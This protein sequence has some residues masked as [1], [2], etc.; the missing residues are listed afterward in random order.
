MLDR[1]L[2]YFSTSE[3]GISP[4]ALILPALL[5]AALVY[6]W[7]CYRNW[8]SA[9]RGRGIRYWN[10][11]AFYG[12]LIVLALAL[13]GRMDSLVEDFFAAHMIQ[14]MLLILVAAPLLALGA[15]PQA[16][17]WALPRKTANAVAGG[18]GRR[19]K[20]AAAWSWLTSVWPAAVIFGVNLWFWHIPLFYQAALEL[21]AVH[22][23]EHVTFLLT[24]ALFWWSVTLAMRSSARGGAGL[25]AL[26]ATMLHM[27]LLGALINLASTPIY[28]FYH[29]GSLFG[30]PLTPLAD[31]Q[32]AGLVMWL[33]G[34]VIFFVL[35]LFYGM[36]W[37]ERVEENQNR[38][39][40]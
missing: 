1:Y 33:P 8:R 10:A 12:A 2:F 23:L 5:V 7:G 20:L 31:Q 36:A 15:V 29:G 28:P 25:L 39:D 30:W 17:L 6:G 16:F 18:L 4:D 9:G 3:P 35:I 38:V 21:N 27:G 26:A 13:T 37:I 22:A 14:H 11:A 40:R 32:L 24:A 19:K 34:G